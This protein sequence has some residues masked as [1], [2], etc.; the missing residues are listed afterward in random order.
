MVSLQNGLW[1]VLFKP[2]GGGEGGWSL[3]PVHLSGRCFDLFQCSSGTSSSGSYICKCSRN[4]LSDYA[5][6]IYWEIPILSSCGAAWYAAQDGSCAARFY[7]QNQKQLK[8][9][10]IL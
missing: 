5:N 4:F 1:N 10:L 7:S 2:G 8:K 6:K 3:S 9:L